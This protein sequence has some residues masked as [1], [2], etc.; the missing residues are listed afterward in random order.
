MWRQTPVTQYFIL[1]PVASQH[2]EGHS[3]SQCTQKHARQGAL[4]SPHWPHLSSLLTNWL[5]LLVDQSELLLAGGQ[6]P[7]CHT[8]RVICMQA[9]MIITMASNFTDT[10]LDSCEQ[11]GGWGGYMCHDDMSGS[12]EGSPSDH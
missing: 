8:E 9:A 4:L 12:C 2:F 6:A 7:T 11:S 1:Y 3:P 10:T 5:A